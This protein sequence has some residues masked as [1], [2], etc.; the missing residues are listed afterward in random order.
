MWQLQLTV[1]R[2]VRAVTDRALHRA[3]TACNTDNPYHDKYRDKL[4]K[5]LGWVWMAHSMGLLLSGYCSSDGLSLPQPSPVARAAG[6]TPYSYTASPVSIIMVLSY[7]R[8]YVCVF[9]NLTL[10]LKWTLYWTRLV[11]RLPAW[12]RVSCCCICVY[13]FPVA[14]GRVPQ[15]ERLC[16]LLHAFWPVCGNVY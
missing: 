6:S 9:R 15:E 11:L 16:W 5:V 14:V 2:C 13:V 7:I 3:V 8:M 10:C 12:V 1:R 4:E